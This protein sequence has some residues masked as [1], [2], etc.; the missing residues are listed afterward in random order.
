MRIFII[1]MMGAGKSFL[2][3]QLAS[4]LAIPFYD[5]DEWIIEKEQ[6]SIKDIFDTKGEPIFRLIEK[7][8]IHTFD[9]IPSFILATG[10]GTPCYGNLIEWMNQKG[11]TIWVQTDEEIIFQRL[12]KEQTH[13]PAIQ[14]LSQDKL[15]YFIH[16]KNTERMPVYQQAD[17]CFS[18]QTNIEQLI[19]SIQA[20]DRKKILSST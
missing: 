1:G 11:I 3:N 9:Y 10:G 17:I 4:L 12:L 8:H 7:K 6:Q 13:R 2:G 18:T 14:C 19:T 16:E 15:R 20:T 5:L